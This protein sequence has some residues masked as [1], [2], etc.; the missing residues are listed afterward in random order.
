M[1]L[2]IGHIEANFS[3]DVDA[4]FTDEIHPLAGIV[5][6]QVCYVSFPWYIEHMNIVLLFIHH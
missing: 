2:L 3:P 1:I 6:S 5:L 4:Y